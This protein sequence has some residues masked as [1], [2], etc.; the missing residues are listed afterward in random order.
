MRT[1]LV[2]ILLAAASGCSS[3]STVEK[4]CDRADSCD[5]LL[6]SVSECVQIFDDVLDD[7]PDSQRDE[8]EDLLEEC[9]DHPSCTGFSSCLSSL[10]TRE[11]AAARLM[12]GPLASE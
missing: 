1:V 5:I 12:S 8:A 4:F 2:I 9:L 6:T 11:D 10:R 3:P 7:L